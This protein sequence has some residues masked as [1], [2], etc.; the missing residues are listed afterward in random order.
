MKKLLGILIGLVGV[1]VGHVYGQEENESE[2]RWAIPLTYHVFH[3]SH[4]FDECGTKVPLA[5]ALV[6]PRV[7]L[8]DI[9]L[10]SRLSA[11]G[12][13][14]LTT[15][16]E[17]P[18]PAPPAPQPPFGQC[19]NE[20]YLA[21]LAPMEIEFKDGTQREV[22]LDINA[23]YRFP[24]N[25][26]ETVWAN[27]GYAIPIKSKIQRLC[28]EQTGDALL[29]QADPAVQEQFF[30]DFKN[31][32]DFLQRGVFA[33]KG[34]RFIPCDTRAGIGDISFS[35]AIEA[36]KAV[37]LESLQFGANLVIPT[38]F[39]GRGDTIGEVTLGAGAYDAELYG[40]VNWRTASNAWNPTLRAA[41]G[42]GYMSKNNK[43]NGGR[44]LRIPQQVSATTGQAVTNIKNLVAPVFEQYFSQD[45]NEISSTV[46]QFSDFLVPAKLHIGPRGLFAVGNYFYNLFNLPDMRFGLFYDF[47]AKAQDRV[48]AL[49]PGEFNVNALSEGTDF[50]AHRV[51][52]NLA[53][54]F[55]NAFEIT[56]GSQ[57]IIAGINTPQSNEFNI[58]LVAV[59]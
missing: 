37:D 27:V 9:F 3:T 55:E 15:P 22:G 25:G 50:R 57:H 11:Q 21:L 56:I 29:T 49:V 30:T 5:A 53:Y 41:V 52:F 36:G 6:G 2:K 54:T 38:G 12:K 8:Q 16:V 35:A 20:Q 33:P 31:V 46:P 39:A 23:F 42:F 47:S 48:E 58:S 32:E 10:L 43:M 51:G 26:D 24:L 45:F 13:L 28:L 7:E 59:F 40:N 4:V 44:G 34:L 14:Y 1:V 19:P 17:C 18:P